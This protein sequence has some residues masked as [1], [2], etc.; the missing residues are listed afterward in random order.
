[1]TLFR[2]EINAFRCS[3]L[4]K[5]PLMTA[6]FVGLGAVSSAH[7][8]DDQSLTWNGI[9]LYG[10]YDIG[11]GYQSHGAPLSA[12]W[13]V[14]V[15]YLIDKKSN[16]SHTGL[17]P[18]GLSQSR[19][20]LRGNEKINDDLAFVFNVEMGFDPQSGN[21]ADALKSLQHNNGLAV[22]QQK[23]SGDSS[24]A[25]QFFNGPGYGGLSSKEFGTLT[26]GRHNTLLLDNILKYDPMGGSYAFSIIGL[27]GVVA[28]M[29]D[30]E[31]ARL[32]GSLKYLYKNDFWHA[33]AMY[34]PG[35]VDS[36]PG[37]AWQGDFGI[38]YAG[39][40]ADAVYGHKKDAIS[41]T[42]LSAAQIAS[43]LPNDSLAATISD[44]TSYTLAAS[45]AIGAWKAFAGYEH[46]KYE[47]PDT[48]IT[49][50]F[51]GLGG[52][53][54]SVIN[55]AA[56]PNDKV[57]QV[58]WAGLRYGITKDFDVTA[59]AYHYDQNSYGVTH[60]S[61]KSAG[62]CS[63]TEDV[64]S[65][66]GDYRWTSR[67]DTYAGA[68]WSGVYDGLASGFLHNSTISPTVGFRFKF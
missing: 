54:L 43:G 31:D 42:F 27:S 11:V 62:T 20:G 15:Q 24:R 25:G 49:T 9:T 44:N 47:N 5:L 14:G 64:Y 48:P 58:S 55:N 39:F 66:M 65:I 40:E 13:F 30:T 26:L 6:A 38:S 35:K 33:G 12:D 2:A 68:M 53:Y 50:P 8:A 41:A 21:L 36:S 32:D 7:A 18:D 23:S 60:C 51:S 67:F 29:G 57:L 59:A 34:Q 4:A 10:V 17:A 22:D 3:A 45:Y 1:M 19:I 16:K 28:G 46:I 63:G 52:Y 37:E 61:D 56:F